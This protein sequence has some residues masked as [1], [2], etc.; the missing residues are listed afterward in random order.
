M[1][2]RAS[3]TCTATFTNV[4]KMTIHRIAKPAWAPSVVVAISSPDPTIEAL[5]ISPGPRYRTLCRQPV[6][7]SLMPSAVSVY[8]SVAVCS[9]LVVIVECLD[10]LD[11]SDV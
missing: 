3:S 2:H 1:V 6:G 11:P 4:L 10:S 8:G 9:V 7:G 5:R